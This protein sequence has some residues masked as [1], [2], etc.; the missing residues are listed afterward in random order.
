MIVTIEDETRK[1]TTSGFIGSCD[2]NARAVYWAMPLKYRAVNTLNGPRTD[3]NI[4][5]AF[6]QEELSN[7]VHS[8]TTK[9]LRAVTVFLSR[10]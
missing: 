7:A 4:F 3:L 1:N 2:F 9:N 6:I 8:Y 5:T 10:F